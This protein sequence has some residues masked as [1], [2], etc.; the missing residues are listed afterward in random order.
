VR[1]RDNAPGA[2]LA[3]GSH[4]AYF[5]PGVRDRTFRFSGPWAT[6]R[7]L[8]RLLGVWWRRRTARPKA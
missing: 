6:K 2:F 3:Y 4:A 5:R 7:G 1:T 8:L